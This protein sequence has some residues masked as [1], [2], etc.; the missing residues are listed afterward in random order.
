MTKFSDD[1]F[2][3]LMRE[4]RTTL[5]NVVPPTPPAHRISGRQMALATGGGL[6]V[7]A[8]VAGTLVATSGPAATVAGSTKTPAYAVTQ[9][10]DGT[11]TLTAYQKSGL[12]GINA[13]LKKLGDKNVYVVPVEAGC[14]S[15]NSLPKPPVSGVGHRIGTAIGVSSNGS[16][17]VQ[18]TG[19]PAGDI[20]V[21]GMEVSG[22]SRLGA[23][24]LTTAPPPKCVSLSVPPPGKAA[25]A[26]TNAG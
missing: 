9:N 19:I 16:V 1:L 21:I 5:A 13:D 15:I 4:H 26:P 20:M 8:A 14:P 11:L 17:T 2:D 3:D 24:T 23:G 22:K 10:P 6:A 25:P 7:A 12:A 18:A